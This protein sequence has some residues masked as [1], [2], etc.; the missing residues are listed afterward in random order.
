VLGSRR[1]CNSKKHSPPAEYASIS[2]WVFW[3]RRTKFCASVS[4]FRYSKS[5]SVLP[6]RSSSP[7]DQGDVRLVKGISPCPRWPLCWGGILPSKIL[8]W[9]VGDVPLTKPW[10]PR[11]NVG[12]AEMGVLPSASNDQLR[13]HICVPAKVHICVQIYTQSSCTYLSVYTHDRS[14]I[15]HHT[16]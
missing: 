16:K 14:T 3:S 5:I 12:L 15:S 8:N 11:C 1:G 10:K 9:R 13:A 2:R 6:H 7:L 4:S